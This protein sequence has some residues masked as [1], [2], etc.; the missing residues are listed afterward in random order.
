LV[1]GV[2]VIVASS[3]ERIE[4]AITVTTHLSVFVEA[5]K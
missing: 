3:A 5:K 2:A 4:S 1:D